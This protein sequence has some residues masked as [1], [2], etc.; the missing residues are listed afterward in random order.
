MGN[1][2][3][4]ILAG[5]KTYGTYTKDHNGLTYFFERGY[6]PRFD[7]GV[8][9]EWWDLKQWQWNIKVQRRGGNCDRPPPCDR[10]LF[11][12]NA[13]RGVHEASDEC[14]S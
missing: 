8:H 2:I 7:M 11:V 5:W 4:A 9:G 1:N 13:S 6:V 10:L 14:R 12:P 3:A